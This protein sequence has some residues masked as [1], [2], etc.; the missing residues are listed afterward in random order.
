M[1][2]AT[3]N[4]AL[5]GIL[6][7]I[8]YG[9]EVGL[10][11]WAGG[12]DLR[13]RLDAAADI[14]LA[15]SLE[16]VIPGASVLSLVNELL[17]GQQ[18]I[19]P[20]QKAFITKVEDYC[21]GLGYAATTGAAAAPALAAYLLAVGGWR[22]PY[23]AA[24][25]YQQASGKTIPARQV[26]GSGILPADGVDP[27][28]SGLHE[29]GT[30]TGDAT[31][32]AGGA[33]PAGVGPVGIVAINL[34]D[35]QTVGGVFT[36]QNYV[37]PTTSKDLTLALTGADEF[38]QTVLGAQDLAAGAAAGTSALQVAS[39]A[40]FTVGEYVLVRESDALQEVAPV[41]ALGTGPTRLVLGTGEGESAVAYELVNTYTTDAK[42][43][44]LFK[45]VTFKD[46]GSGTGDVLLAG[47][48]DWTIEA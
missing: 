32:V 11:V 10:D 40:A 28:G 19:T 23:Q 31:W 47:L 6:G 17:A 7:H 9:S 43:Y 35:A 48:T 44:P 26:F 18:W 16:N 22:V 33:L 12:T 46:T 39:T 42:V 25:R 8:A 20:L 13:T 21:K 38:T 15:T 41:Q 36:C 37:D 1:S 14:G 5:R 45:G 29:F 34:G 4:Q 2:V 30:F 27:T 24:L 3:A